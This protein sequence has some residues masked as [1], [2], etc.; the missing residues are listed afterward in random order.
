VIG[1]KIEQFDRGVAELDDS[2]IA[3][4]LIREWRV[5]VFERSQMLCGLLVRDDRRPGIF[6]C[7]SAGD[8][9]VVMV[10][11]DQ[12]FDRLVGNLLDLI[13]PPFGRP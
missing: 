4:R 11:I 12:I 2:L 1:T 10:A 13:W 5:R 6:E 7:L 3:Y 9:I 8:V